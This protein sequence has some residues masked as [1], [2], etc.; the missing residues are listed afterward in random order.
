HAGKTTERNMNGTTKTDTRN[1]LY[2]LLRRS[3]PGSTRPMPP[4][5]SAERGPVLLARRDALRYQ[6]QMDWAPTPIRN[7]WLEGADYRYCLGS[8][9]L[10]LAIRGVSAS[11]EA[12]VGRAEAEFALVVA[13]PL[14]VFGSRFGATVP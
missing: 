5:K 2:G 9:Q 7:P 11:Q 14:L 13:G 12:A 8:H 4:A 10:I 3:K 1:R 6:E